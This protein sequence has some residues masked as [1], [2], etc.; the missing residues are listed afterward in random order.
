MNKAYDEKSHSYYNRPD[1]HATG[2][3]I[4]AAE[5]NGWLVRIPPMEFTSRYF[6]RFHVLYPDGRYSQYSY[7]HYLEAWDSVIPIM[8]TR[9]FT[10]RNNRLIPI[11]ETKEDES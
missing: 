5:S 8:R 6:G 10:G 4:R 1:N 9:T 3:E 11:W 2:D 7:E